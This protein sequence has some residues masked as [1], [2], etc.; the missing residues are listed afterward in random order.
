MELK[1]IIENKTFDEER[2]LYNLKDTE[3]INCTF[4]GEL[5]RR[6]SIKRNKKYK[7]KRQ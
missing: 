6:V 3:V 5:D 4:A 2:A 1:E 7:S